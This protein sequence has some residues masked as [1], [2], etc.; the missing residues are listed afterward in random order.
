VSTEN[1]FAGLRV[2][3][4]GDVEQVWHFNRLHAKPTEVF[5]NLKRTPLSGVIKALPYCRK[6]SAEGA[7]CNLVAFCS[8]GLP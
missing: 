8:E 3:F 4:Y 1:A 7:L 6:G 2:S 5:A